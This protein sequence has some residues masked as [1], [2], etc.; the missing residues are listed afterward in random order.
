MY[1]LHPQWLTKRKIVEEGTEVVI[2]TN[3]S[4]PGFRFQFPKLRSTWSIAPARVAVESK[5]P[6]M[7]CGQVVASVLRALPET[8]LVA[9]GN[10][11]VYQADAGELATLSA[12]IREFPRQEG[13]DEGETVLQ[14]T[15]H[16]GV[17]CGDHALVNLQISIKEDALELA[18]NVH[19]G[20]ENLP[21]AN[22]LAITAAEK[23]FEDRTRSKS[24]AEHFFGASIHDDNNHS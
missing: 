6:G 1:I 14:R 19:T 13:P 23:F 17:K 20:L 16:V 7:D 22:A 3:L 2:E 24:L 15:F 4:Q 8:P 18:C 12:A 9:L 21:D 10:N 5:D 11:V